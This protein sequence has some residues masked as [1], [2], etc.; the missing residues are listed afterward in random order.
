MD[1]TSKNILLIFLFVLI[2]YL[3]SVLSSLLLPLAIAFLMASLF[4]PLITFLSKKKIPNFIIL[5]LISVI[6]LAVLYGIANII[7]ETVDAISLQQDYLLVR[8]Q[9]KFQ[10]LVLWL[11]DISG[12]DLS[13]ASFIEELESLLSAERLSALIGSVARGLGSFTGSFFMF[14]LY[15]IVLLSG[16]ASTEKYIKY[17]AGPK[18]DQAFKK[19]MQMQ[20]SIISYM[21]WKTLI[22]LFTGG[23]VAGVC[24]MFDIK[25]AIFWG[26][27]AFILNYIPSIGSI[28]ATIPPILMGIIELESL[29][30]MI[31]LTAL[32][33]AIQVIVGNVVEPLIMGNRLKLNTLTVLFGLVFWGYL[34]GVIGMMLSVPLM[35]V[36]KIVFEQTESLGFLA[37]MME[38]PDD[39]IVKLNAKE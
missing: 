25:F 31:L 10:S 35:V 21:I 12:T 32:L 17:V 38:T 11:N 9:S 26:F 3:L 24:F 15:Y 18:G 19:Y 6:T 27:I 22:S 16:M 23:L 20:N 14:S 37:R 8:L 30:A 13:Q 2:F 5:P 34:W 28:A 7:I 36:L 4:S 39:N 33:T 1:K 29:N